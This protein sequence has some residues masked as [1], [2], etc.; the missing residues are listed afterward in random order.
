M[1][2]KKMIQNLV[3]IK[4]I[5]F[6]SIIKKGKAKFYIM[7]NKKNRYWNICLRYLAIS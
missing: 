7:K 5:A 3:A 1:E 6:E 2:I 4:L